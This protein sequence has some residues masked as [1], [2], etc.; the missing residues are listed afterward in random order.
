MLRDEKVEFIPINSFK[1]IEEYLI[2]KGVIE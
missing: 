1:D 2:D